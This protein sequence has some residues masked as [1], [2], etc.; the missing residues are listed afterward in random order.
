M[1]YLQG[2]LKLY[3]QGARFLPTLKPCV[4]IVHH[5]HKN[6]AYII[7][8]CYNKRLLFANFFERT[9]PKIIL[10]KDDTIFFW[11]ASWVYH[12]YIMLNISSYF[13]KCIIKIVS[14]VQVVIAIDFVLGNALTPKYFLWPSEKYGRNLNW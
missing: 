11:K 6:S 8:S 12:L 9:H 14:W 13:V 10:C 3:K 2:L 1:Y 7:K 5:T 4:L